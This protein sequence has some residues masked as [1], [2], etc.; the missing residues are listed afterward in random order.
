MVV[1][2]QSVAFV[3]VPCHLETSGPNA[4]SWVVDMRY[5]SAPLLQG[6]H[7]ASATIVYNAAVPGAGG[8]IPAGTTQSWSRTVT[9]N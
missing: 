3:W 1:D 6:T 2:G 7:T 9:V 5:L 8:G 4:Q